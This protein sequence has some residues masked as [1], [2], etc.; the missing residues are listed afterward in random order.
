MPLPFSPAALL[1]KNKLANDKPWL[2]LLELEL[3]S[4]DHIYIVRNNEEVTWNGIV[5]EPFPVEPDDKTQ[6]MKSLPS[7]NVKIS[8]V[9][10]IIQAYLEEFDGLTDCEVILRLVHAAHL[11]LTT[12]EMEETFT[13]QETSYDEQW[14]TFSLGADFWFFYRA[15]AGRYLKDWCSF[16][17]GGIKCGVNAAC[18]AQYSTCTHTLTACRE[19]MAASGITKIRFDGEPS[20]QGGLY[21]SN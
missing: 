8:N 11:D 16:K 13:I 2:L 15:L 17:Y 21:A 6:D 20:L 12:P 4:G 19:R 18:L 9:D 7:F 3:P 10:H 14:V 1:E 5:W